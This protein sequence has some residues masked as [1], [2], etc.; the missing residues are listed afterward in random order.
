MPIIC[1]IGGWRDA[2]V[3][4]T[5]LAEAKNT[6]STRTNICTHSSNG[7]MHNHKDRSRP[8]HHHCRDFHYKARKPV[9]QST[10]QGKSPSG[11]K[12]PLRRQAEGPRNDV[13]VLEREA[14]APNLSS[15]GGPHHSLFLR[16]APL[17]ICR[18]KRP[19]ASEEGRAS[20]RGGG[21]GLEPGSLVPPQGPPQSTEGGPGPARAGG[22]LEPASRAGSASPCSQ[23]KPPSGFEGPLQ[24][25]SKGETLIFLEREAPAPSGSAPIAICQGKRPPVPEKGSASTRGVGPGLEP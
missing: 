6:D 14:P 2:N 24:R 23:G 15:G 22:R 13:F 11:F 12:G 9:I 25:R 1:N 7:S 18:G 8:E 19:P 5:A 20:T 16:A 21:P 17:A 4:P 10:T 3:V